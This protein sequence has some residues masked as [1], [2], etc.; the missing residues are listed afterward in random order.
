MVLSLNFVVIT[1]QTT[2][3]LDVL[4]LLNVEPWFISAIFQTWMIPTGIV[5]HYTPT[6]PDI[7]PAHQWSERMWSMWKKSGR[8]QVI[9]TRVLTHIIEWVY[10]LSTGKQH[11]QM[12]KL[13][14]TLISKSMD[15]HQSGWGRCI[16]FSG[17]LKPFF[18]TFFK[19]DMLCCRS[20]FLWG[21][22]SSVGLVWSEQGSVQMLWDNPSVS[23]T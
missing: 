5:Y 13:I 6:W 20:H 10:V 23:I 7:T 18:S 8:S 15:Y 2:W 21:Q 16:I 4:H 11:A 17:S 12:D 22:I 14:F 9:P 3:D 19:L 1:H